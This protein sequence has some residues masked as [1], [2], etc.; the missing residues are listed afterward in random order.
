MLNLDKYSGELKKI[1]SDLKADEYRINI[2]PNEILNNNKPV[3]VIDIFI[4]HI[5]TK[6]TDHYLFRQSPIYLKEFLNDCLRAFE[7]R[8][9]DEIKNS[10]PTNSL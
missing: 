4:E 7:K 5:P 10:V 6:K 1:I 8:I 9:Y 2:V 3:D